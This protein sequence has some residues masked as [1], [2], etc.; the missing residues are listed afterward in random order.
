MSIRAKNNTILVTPDYTVLKRLS[1]FHTDG[2]EID[3]PIFGKVKMHASQDYVNTAPG[4]NI[5]WGK[6]MSVGPG[7]PW[8]A[9]KATLDRQLRAGD[10]IGFDAC[11]Q[12]SAP[13]EGETVFFLPVD[14]ALCRFNPEDPLPVPLGVHVL[15]VHED[16]AAERFTFRERKT[17]LVLPRNAAAGSIKVSDSPH[18]QVKFTVERVLDVGPGGMGHDEIRTELSVHE[19]VREQVRVNG[20]TMG[21]RVISSKVIEKRQ[22]PVWI[23]PEVTA[24][25]QLALFLFT[26]SVDVLIN[27]VRHRLTNW[28]RVRCLVDEQETA[29]LPAVMTEDELFEAHLDDLDAAGY[30]QRWGTV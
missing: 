4:N 30:K 3:H 27:G 5:A 26:M 8:M 16:G 1:Q 12:V 2:E 19:E 25:G 9:G 11:Q 15:T 20:E 28:A 7:A 6:V 13:F 14:A 22:T 24:I 17:K 29:A 10:I 18:S 23:Q 21:S